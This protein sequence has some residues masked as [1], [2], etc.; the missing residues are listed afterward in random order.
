M[1]ND[2][3][4]KL[5]N[6][7]NDDTIDNK[8]LLL[9]CEHLYIDTTQ[10]LVCEKCAYVCEDVYSNEKVNYD[11]QRPYV[12]FGQ[13]STFVAFSYSKTFKSLNRLHIWTNNDNSYNFRK[14]CTIDVN[15]LFDRYNFSKEICK[16]VIIGLN[17]LYVDDYV[18]FRGKIKYGIYFTLILELLFDRDL[19]TDAFTTALRLEKISYKNF[20]D[21]SKKLSANSDREYL[22]LPTFLDAILLEQPQLKLKDIVVEYNKLLVLKLN[23]RWRKMKVLILEKLK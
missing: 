14:R 13:N 20:N 21:A 3:F 1:Y 12:K 23:Y 15:N 19:N 22:L 17:E 7:F 16:S 11:T 6:Y 18:R 2:Y 5:D 4:N 8:E 10:S 9:K